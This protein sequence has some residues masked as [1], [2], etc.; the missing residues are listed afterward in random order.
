MCNTQANKAKPGLE[1]RPALLTGLILP[2]QPRPP[3][4]LAGTEHVVGDA[5][6]GGGLAHRPLHERQVDHLEDAGLHLGHAGGPRLPPVAPARHPPF[7]P[8]VEQPLGKG[9]GPSENTP[10][11]EPPGPNTTP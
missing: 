6:P 11:Q 8:S 1:H 2:P 9:E 5:D 7:E 4:A 3:R 10:A